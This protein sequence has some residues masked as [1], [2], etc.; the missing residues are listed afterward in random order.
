[1]KTGNIKTINHPLPTP[2]FLTNIYIYISDGK[3]QHIFNTANYYCQ[4]NLYTHQK[5]YENAETTLFCIGILA[6]IN[7][8]ESALSQPIFKESS[9]N[10]LMQNTS[11]IF[12]V[13][14]FFTTVCNK[15][16]FFNMQISRFFRI[17]G[18]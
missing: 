13:E 15:K 16:L 2:S 4:G 6:T 5:S 12:V 3:T 10:I 1:M 17:W 14:T 18:K 7:I 9:C 11:I 8:V